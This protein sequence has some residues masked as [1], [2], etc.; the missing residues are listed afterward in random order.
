MGPKLQHYANILFLTTLFPLLLSFI[1]DFCLQQY[2]CA[3]CLNGDFFYLFN[4]FHT[5]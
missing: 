2:Y 5:Y 4:S 3:V 1:N